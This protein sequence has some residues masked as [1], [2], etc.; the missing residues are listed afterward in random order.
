MVDRA[1]ARKLA[2]RIRHV[3]AEALERQ[4]KDPRLSLVTVTD[5][6]LTG[7]LREAT[8]FYTVLGDDAAWADSAAALASATGV[9]RSTVGR[10]LGVRFTP[11]ITFVADHVPSEGRR[12]EALLAAA[13]DADATL[14]E[15]RAGKSPAGEPDP[16]RHREEQTDADD[17]EGIHD[18]G[19]ADGTPAE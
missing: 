2:V 10:A 8:V 18:D 9:V 17:P 11:T 5:T 19:G 13:R 4:I 6:R 16:Y 1:R 12:V 14:S 3:V 7:D 15:V